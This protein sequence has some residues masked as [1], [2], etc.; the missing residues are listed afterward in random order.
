M[1]K[2][3]F[4]AMLLLWKY[5]DAQDSCKPTYNMPVQKL[6]VADGLQMAYVEKGKGETIVFVHGLGGNLSHWLKQ[7]DALSKNYHCIAV[8]LPGYGYSDKS[9]STDK[10]HLAFYADVLSAFIEKKGLEKV[11]LAGHSMGGQIAIITAINHPEKISKLVLAAP[12]GLETFSEAETK[13]ITAATPPALFEKQE[14]PVIR[15]S[16]K[17]NFHEQPQ[18]AEA[19]IQDRIRFKTCADFKLYT[20]AVSG[21]I[22]A[23]LAHPVKA[24]L[25]KIKQPVLIIFGGED[26]LIPNKL[27]HPTLV[28]EEMLKET[29]TLMPKAILITIPSA[30]HLVQFE[31]SEETI[32]AIKY[33]LR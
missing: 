13:M 33:F 25:P 30:G 15:Y 12:A 23:M 24:D 26:A 1:K 2:L 8:D 22:K 6:Q 5:S 9:F 19:L 4:I 17:Q 14:E 16:F 28:R 11:V 3:L 29:L 20:D 21:G 27:L 31:K 18:D 10:D 7:V 32:N